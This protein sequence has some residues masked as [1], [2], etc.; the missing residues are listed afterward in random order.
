MFG[1]ETLES[2]KDNRSIFDKIEN[3]YVNTLTYP[4]SHKSKSIKTIET[5][6][7]H[8]QMPVSLKYLKR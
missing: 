3:G 4:F 8:K 2:D 5:S 6:I 1:L 7:N